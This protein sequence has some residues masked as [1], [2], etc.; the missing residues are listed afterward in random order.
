MKT[1]LLHPAGPVSDW[2]KTA[3]GGLVLIDELNHRVLMQSA[4]GRLRV[5]ATGFR[6]PRSVVVMDSMAYVVDSWNHRVRAF[7]LPEWR[8]AFEFGSFFCPSWI[9]AMNGLLVVADTNNQ[10][11]SFHEPNGS[12]LFTYSLDGFP[13]RV[14][15]NSN[16]G[17]IVYYDDGEMETLTY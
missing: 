10:R 12:P 6:Y 17:I 16:G 3:D 5:A 13:K 7:D 8:S 4:D 11:L 2:A 1:S 9:A 15:T 14:C